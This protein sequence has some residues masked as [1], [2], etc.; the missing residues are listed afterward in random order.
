MIAKKFVQQMRVHQ[1]QWLLDGKGTTEDLESVDRPESW[2]LNET[3]RKLNLYNPEWWKYIA[4]REHRWARSLNSSQCFAVNLFAPLA[5]D[6]ELAKTVMRRIWPSRVA[7]ALESVTIKFEHTPHG[8]PGW[9]GEQKQATQVDVFVLARQKSGAE[10]CLLIEVK[11]SETR[12]GSCRGAEPTSKKRESN[13][14]PERCMDLVAILREPAR[15]CW[16]AEVHSRTYWNLFRERG[17]SFSFGVPDGGRSCPFRGGLYQL[18]RNRVLA[19]QL[20]GHGKV[21][22]A[23]LAVCAHPGNQAVRRLKEAVMGQY[24]VLAA[25]RTIVPRAPILE[26]DPRAV[27]RAVRESSSEWND[28]AEAMELR[29]M[30]TDI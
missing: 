23:D 7:E 16:L 11:L 8:A 4:G 21:L 25:F 30:L 22:W 27:V 18:M 17:S 2:V 3:S 26:I 12:F 28:W 29:Y 15:Q 6:P 20:V 1:R 24:D 13:P 19:D 5:E 14:H 9:L 10:G